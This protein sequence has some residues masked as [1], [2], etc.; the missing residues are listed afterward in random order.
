MRTAQ[1][2][3]GSGALEDIEA[4]DSERSRVFCSSAM[5]DYLVT[6]RTLEAPGLY[7]TLPSHP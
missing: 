5:H 7:A 4:C 2:M 1:T 3:K 6:Y